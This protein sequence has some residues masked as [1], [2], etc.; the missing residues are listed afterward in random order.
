MSHIEYVGRPA[1]WLY[2][3]RDLVG[4]LKFIEEPPVL[5]FFFGRLAPVGDWPQRLAEA[6]VAEFGAGC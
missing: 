1:H 5:R 4:G 6:F 2:Q 3:H